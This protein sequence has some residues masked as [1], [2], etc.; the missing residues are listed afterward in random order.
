MPFFFQA[1]L[2]TIAVLN[3]HRTQPGLVRVQWG[4]LRSSPLNCSK[5]SVKLISH[6][7]PKKNK[8]KMSI[9]TCQGFTGWEIEKRHDLQRLTDQI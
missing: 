7:V 3:E 9:C 2:C 1:V 4:H 6:P 8:D 5:L